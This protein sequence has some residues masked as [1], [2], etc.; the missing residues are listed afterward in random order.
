MPEIQNSKKYDLEERTYRFASRCRD[1]IKKL[2]RTISNVEY[3][4]QLMRSSGSQAANYIEANESLSK[5][6]FVHRIKICRKETKESCLWLKLCEVG[7]N[8]DSEKE[9]QYLLGEALE[10]RKIFTSILNKSI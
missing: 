4:R 10:L 7:K 3:E 6:D 8:E 1:F 5:K 9:R 2:P